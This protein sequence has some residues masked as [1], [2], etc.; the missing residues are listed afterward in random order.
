[1]ELRSK[2]LVIFLFV[3]ISGDDI[4][5]RLIP[6]TVH[7]GLSVYSEKKAE[8]IRK[9]SQEIEDKNQ[10]LDS[11]MLRYK[12]SNRLLFVIRSKHRKIFR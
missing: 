8:L 11:F 6:M 2:I 1:M 9:I 3:Q 12:V 7:E 5:K 10:D 4:F